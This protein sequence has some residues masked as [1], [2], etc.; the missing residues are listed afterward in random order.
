MNIFLRFAAA[1][2]TLS[3]ATALSAAQDDPDLVLVTGEHWA[4]SS[5]EQ[6]NA[7]L[8]GVGNVIEIEQ[9][10]QGDNPSSEILSSSMIP[11]LVKGLSPMSL[12]DVREALSDW[13]ESHPEQIKRPVLEVLYIEIALPNTLS[14]SR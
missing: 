7:F 13:Y 3:M 2:L 6:K 12:R 11:V 1:V 10:M 14:A 4:P 8:F 9:A 5:L